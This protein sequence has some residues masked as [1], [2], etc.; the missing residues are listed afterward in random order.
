MVCRSGGVGIHSMYREVLAWDVEYPRAK[1]ISS[2]RDGRK[3]GAG[4]GDGGHGVWGAGE[5]SRVIAPG[6]CVDCWGGSVSGGFGGL[7]SLGGMVLSECC[8]G[9]SLPG[10]GGVLSSLGGISHGFGWVRGKLGDRGFGKSSSSDDD[11]V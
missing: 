10:S 11:K 6:G 9:V 7:S 4:V 1:S 2:I 5:R 8:S 3:V